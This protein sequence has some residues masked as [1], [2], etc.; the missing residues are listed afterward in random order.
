MLCFLRSPTMA[1]QWNPN[2]KW[3]SGGGASSSLPWQSSQ[4]PGNHDSRRV[5]SQQE[6]RQWKTHHHPKRWSNDVQNRPDYAS[7][8]PGL[9]ERPCYHPDKKRPLNE[10]GPKKTAVDIDAGARLVIVMPRGLQELPLPP[11]RGHFAE[12]QR[13]VKAEHGVDLT[14]RA[15]TCEKS[16]APRITMLSLTG[17]RNRVREA[18]G[19]MW[20]MIP[21]PDRPRCLPHPADVMEFPLRLAISDGETR[22]IQ[23]ERHDPITPATDPNES[24]E[25]LALL[26]NA[27]APAP[28]AERLTFESLDEVKQPTDEVVQLLGRGCI[29]PAMQSLMITWQ[30]IAPRRCRK[31]LMPQWLWR[32]RD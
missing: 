10:P 20:M 28:V 24:Q 23:E 13:A 6:I 16:R 19:M 25:A 1:S 21:A 8:A 15:R 17:L 18:Y 31:D 5:Y 2:W 12:L 32:S 26:A 14:L 9:G 3:S 11:G 7:T 4:T 30:L 29:P 27:S 22:H